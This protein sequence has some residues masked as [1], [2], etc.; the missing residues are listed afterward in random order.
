[1]RSMLGLKAPASGS[2]LRARGYE[3]GARMGSGQFGYAVLVTKACPSGAPESRTY[4]AKLQK[5][6]HLPSEDK[7]RMQ[8]EV[9]AMR[10]LAEAGHPYLVRFRE[11]FV[12]GDKLC[13]I[14]DYCDSG[15]LAVRIKRQ[16]EVGHGQ[17]FPEAQVQRWLAQLIA[18][19]DFLHAMHVLHRDIKPSSERLP[20]ATLARA[21]EA[22]A[23][24][25]PPRGV[26]ARADLFLHRGSELKIGDLGLSKQ[27]LAGIAGA[28][29]HTQ[30][31][32]P[33]Y[34]APEVHMSQAYDGKVDIWAAG[35]TLYEVMM[36][37]RAFTG[38]D[39]EEIL[40]KVVYAVR[41][42]RRRRRHREAAA[43]PAAPLRH[44]HSNTARSLA[45]GRPNWRSCC[46]RCSG[47]APRS[48][49]RRASSSRARTSRRRWRRSTRR[50]SRTWCAPRR[51]RRRRH[52]AS[53]SPDAS[54]RDACVSAGAQ[55]NKCC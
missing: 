13:I 48:G 2:E 7:E 27:I 28:Q 55:R 6:R 42:P 49:R 32:S 3:A 39:M 41:A 10:S 40:A 37:R 30:C 43:D 36:L 21:S 45:T 26:G 20:P 38:D 31:G 29:K 44:R 19:L 18:G 23:H 51:R 5:F 8:R 22:S 34:L 9:D 35:C 24:L 15:D 53:S 50:P 16:R 46:S 11:S 4:V 52:G 25:I 1:M 14:M 12:E 54:A 47:C 17:Q 33:V